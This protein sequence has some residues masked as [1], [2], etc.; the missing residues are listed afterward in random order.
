MGEQKEGGRCHFL[1][2]VHV[3]SYSSTFA[4][5]KYQSGNKLPL[6]FFFPLC[7]SSIGRTWTC[8]K[9]GR[10]WRGCGIYGWIP[11]CKNATTRSCSYPSGIIY[12]HRW[13]THGIASRWSYVSACGVGDGWTANSVASEN[14]TKQ[15]K[16][17]QR[18]LQYTPPIEDK[19]WKVYYE[20]LGNKIWYWLSH[21][22]H[23]HQ[24]T[25]IYRPAFYS[26]CRR[27]VNH[28]AT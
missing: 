15:N 27:I 17:F 20:A 11:L 13:W 5:D 23:L 14:K 9:P 28:T 22:V 18:L 21:L 26:H 7:R 12:W 1:M 4:S 19:A 6:F 3:T 10:L 2:R 16:H 8:C 25:F 24:V